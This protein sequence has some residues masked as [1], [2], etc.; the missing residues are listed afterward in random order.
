MT[1]K[2]FSRFS[3]CRCTPYTEGSFFLSHNGML[4]RCVRGGQRNNIP[5][6]IFRSLARRPV[7]VEHYNL[8]K[9]ESNETARKIA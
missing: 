5:L 7:R 9:L 6:Y 3:G 4:F 8:S 1:K 2:A